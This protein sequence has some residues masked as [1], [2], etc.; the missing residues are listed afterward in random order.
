MFAT[1][2]SIGKTFEIWPAKLTFAA[3]G[4]GAR[5]ALD[6]AMDAARELS[7]SVVADA[8]LLAKG[9]MNV[10]PRGKA[11]R[12]AI[13]TVSAFRDVCSPDLPPLLAALPGAVCDT[14]L[15]VMLEVARNS[16]GVEFIAVSLG[17]TVAFHQ[18][19]GT[20]LSG[21]VDM[22]PVLGEFLAAL[23]EGACGGV[24]I[25]GVH[26]GMPTQGALDVVAIQSKSAAVAGFAAS[27]VADA[28]AGVPLPVGPAPKDRLIASAW[29]GRPVVTAAGLMEPD[30][31]W[32]V[33]SAAVR[34]ASV[35]RDKRLLSAAALGVKG[36]GR[37]I[38]PVD[39]DRL[40][41]FGVSEWR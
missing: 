18:E 23:G 5:D 33:L 31:L 7:S 10:L 34:Q 20:R 22:P 21:D 19:P 17:D 24:A 9:A 32:Q 3:G 38:G 14:V 11:G 26:S 39:G 35:L 29:E 12:L 28:A 40:L 1:A 4:A 37:T 8:E 13:E 15:D 2:P 16:G 30:I 36:R 6:A 25:G 41:R 27:V